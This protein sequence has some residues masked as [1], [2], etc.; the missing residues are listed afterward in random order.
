M[1]VPAKIKAGRESVVKCIYV[2]SKAMPLFVKARCLE[3][4]PGGVALGIDLGHPEGPQVEVGL[5]RVSRMTEGEKPI[6]RSVG[7]RRRSPLAP[8]PKI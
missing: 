2:E 3:A 8:T 5:R 7:N 1:V 4:N 6:I